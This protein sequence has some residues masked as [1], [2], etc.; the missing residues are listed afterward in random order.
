MTF[1][2]LWSRLFIGGIFAVSAITKLRDLPAF[3]ASIADF[4]LLPRRIVPAASVVVLLTELLI[5]I[6]ALHRAT[7]LAAFLLAIAL[8]LAFAAAMWTVVHRGVATTCRCFGTASRVP[9]R[10]AHVWR[11]MVL[12]ACC[13]VGLV[14]TSSDASFLTAGGAAITFALLGAC[15]ALLIVLSLDAILE[16]YSP[17]HTRKVTR[18]R[19]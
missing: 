7:T 9:I 13:C 8:L 10:L 3:R 2:L 19:Q 4:R 16:L 17:Q 1:L 18:T 14:A 15:S 11:N 5:P 12:V 6:L